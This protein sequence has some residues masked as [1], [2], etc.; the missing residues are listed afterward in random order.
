MASGGAWRLAPR[1]KVDTSK[2][3]VGPESGAHFLFTW[4]I[5]RRWRFGVILG[6][7]GCAD[8]SGQDCIFRADQDTKYWISK[9]FLELFYDFGKTFFKNCVFLPEKDIFFGAGWRVRAAG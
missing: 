8:L 1:R 2:N 5:R 7:M 6:F 4:R 9:I 3:K